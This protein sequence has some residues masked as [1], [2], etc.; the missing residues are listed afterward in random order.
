MRARQLGRGVLPAVLPVLL[1]SATVHAAVTVV[2]VVNPNP[3][4]DGQDVEIGVGA[5][6]EVIVDGGSVLASAAVKLGVRNN[7]VDLSVGIARVSGPGS[8]WEMQGLQLEGSLRSLLEVT[9]G[10]QAQIGSFNE[11]GGALREFRVS[12]ESSVLAIGGAF[13]YQSQGLSADVEV[14]S[15]GLLTANEVYLGELARLAL[16]GGAVVTGNFGNDGRVSGDGRVRYSQMESG[17]N[18]GVV[19]VGGDQRLQFESFQGY[20]FQNNGEVAVAGGEFVALHG[21]RNRGSFSGPDGAASI[22]LE[23]GVVRVGPSN[24]LNTNLEN[25][26]RIAAIGGVNDIHGRVDSRDGASIAVTNE[27]VL[28]F[29]D[30][31]LLAQSTLSVFAGSRAVF[32]DGLSLQNATLFAQLP[33]DAGGGGYG[34]AEVVGPLVIDGQLQFSLAGSYAPELG[35]AF[36]LIT[37]SGGVTGDPL[38]TAAPA[39]SAGLRW[40][41]QT[42]ATTLSLAVVEALPGDFNADGVVDA[43][44]Y[45]VWRDNPGGAYQPSD[46]QAWRDNYGA[47][48]AATPPTNNAAPEPGAA[49]LL[50]LV[51]VG[52]LT[53]RRT[54]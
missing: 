11:Y 44:D 23:D 14:A 53:A 52:P 26:G 46:L 2:G 13:G 27:S 17:G 34:V 39:L 21:L 24:R 19:E 43:A 18:S 33:G 9:G 36:P 8:R 48:I 20:P 6:G 5:Y 15:G 35:D 49:L 12:G 4:V 10:A 41:V 7:Q 37:A 1:F 22:T 30:S 25:E 28:R 42:D 29:H 40:Q 45:T 16:D 54:S 3:V 31:V 38:L 32:L 51:A 50:S 47:T